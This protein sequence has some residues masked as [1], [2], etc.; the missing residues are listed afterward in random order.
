MGQRA[1]TSKA[2]SGGPA[3]CTPGTVGLE[4]AVRLLQNALMS[5]TRKN[6]GCVL[7]L[8]ASEGWAD[9]DPDIIAELL[10]AAH[11]LATLVVSDEAASAEVRRVA[12]EFLDRLRS[13]T[14]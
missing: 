10:D 13:D 6:A 3:S 9:Q 11:D 14:Y 7:R 2:T 8:I 12:Q 5:E 1:I 4:A